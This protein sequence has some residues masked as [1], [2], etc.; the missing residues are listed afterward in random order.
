MAITQTPGI[1]YNEINTTPYANG[2][3]AEIPIFIGISGN[4]TPYIGIQKI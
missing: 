4:S 3:G 2:V 1:T